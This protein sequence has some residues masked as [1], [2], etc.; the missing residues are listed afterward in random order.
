[1]KP[2]AF[3]FDAYGTL[4]DVTAA[5]RLAAAEP[6]AEVLVGIW[7]EL[8]DKWRR[9]QL[10]YSWLRAIMGMHADFAEVTADA[11]DWSMEAHG[12]GAEHALR[13]RLLSLY[14][15]LSAYPEVPNVLAALRNKGA[16][17]AI[18][19]NGSPEMLAAAVDSAGITGALDA[20]IS[21]E[22]VQIFKP[23]EVVY[24][25]VEKHLNVAPPQVLFISS[26]GWDVA[27]ASRFGFQTAWVNRSHQP[28]DRLPHGPRHILRD[29]TPLPD[30]F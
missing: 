30:M 9:K 4:F 6:G 27:G 24:S 26:N 10:E 11:L 29:L 16:K 23:A 2:A 14:E 21:V 18:L 13:A 22:E 5:A 20:V 19:S 15:R 25:L 17:L 1:M 8:A 28:V 3:V 7:A 12:L